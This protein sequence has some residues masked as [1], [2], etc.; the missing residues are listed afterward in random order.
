MGHCLK[1]QYDDLVIL[2]SKVDP[3]SMRSSIVTANYKDLIQALYISPLLLEGTVLCSF[4]RITI[5]KTSK[6]IKF[7]FNLIK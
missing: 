2:M 6:L 4:G 1:G 5:K 3:S 7:K